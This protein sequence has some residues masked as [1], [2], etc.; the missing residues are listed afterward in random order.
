MSSSE[1]KDLAKIARVSTHRVR[2]FPPGPNQFK[3][4]KI[5]V[6]HGSYTYPVLESQ[7]QFRIKSFEC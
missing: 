4:E 2:V 6:G 7:K 3:S 1:A 5:H